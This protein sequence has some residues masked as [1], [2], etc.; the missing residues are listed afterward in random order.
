MYLHFL[1]L[2]WKLLISREKL[3]VKKG[4]KRKKFENLKQKRDFLAFS[5]SCIYRICTNIY[6]CTYL[7]NKLNL[8]NLF[9]VECSPLMVEP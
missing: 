2:N 3:K 6:L 9:N 5:I 7:T 1:V 4:T 8:L